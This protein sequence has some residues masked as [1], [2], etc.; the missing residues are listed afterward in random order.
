MGW[1]LTR[2][3]FDRSLDRAKSIR[4]SEEIPETCLGKKTEAKQARGR[5]GGEDGTNL[6]ADADDDVGVA[7]SEVADGEVHPPDHAHPH[8]PDEMVQH[9]SPLFFFFFFFFPSEAPPPPSQAQLSSAT[10]RRRRVWLGLLPLKKELRPARGVKSR[11]SGLAWLL[12]WWRWSGG[13]PPLLIL[14]PPG[15]GAPGW[16]LLV[17]DAVFLGSSFVVPPRLLP[18]KSRDPGVDRPGQRRLWIGT[19]VSNFFL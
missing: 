8:Q 19:C 9:G 11:K 5:K 15:G 13:L 1:V 7:G 3:K 10:S 12:R 14:T 2:T 4:E 17:V 16:Q 6:L 18:G